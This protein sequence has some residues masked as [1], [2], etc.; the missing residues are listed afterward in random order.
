M[1][2]YDDEIEFENAWDKMI[3]KY[4]VG[5]VSWLNNIYKLKTKWARCHMKNAFTLGVRSTQLSESLNGD[6]KAYL[7]SNLSIVEFFQHFEQVIEQKRHK[8]LEAEFNAQ[9]KLPTLGLKNSLC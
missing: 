2:E 8:E 1:F 3:Q 5:S 4:N 6:L 9:E 7:K